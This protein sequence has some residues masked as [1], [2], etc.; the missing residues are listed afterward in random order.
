M[1]TALAVCQEFARR[2]GLAVPTGLFAGDTQALQMASLLNELCDEITTRAGWQELLKRT[3]SWTSTGAV[4]QGT[5]TS[6]FGS[7]LQNVVAMTLWDA[8]DRVVIDGPLT[9]ADW[10]S[11]QVFDVGGS[12]F[13]EYKIYDGHL[14]IEPAVTAG[15]TLTAFYKVNTWVMSSGGTVKAAITADDDQIIFPDALVKTGLRWKW[16]E[17]KGLPYAEI[18]RTFEGMFLDLIANNRAAKVIYMGDSG[19]ELQPGI[20]VP[21]DAPI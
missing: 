13:A 11:G 8:T 16:R 5:L 3:S 18:F 10:Q 9:T 15:N 7:G 6:I 1:A 12:A 21:T 2:T 20:W 14:Y 4:D 19:P 17:E